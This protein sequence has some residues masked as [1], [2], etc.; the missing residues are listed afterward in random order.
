[1]H[2]LFIMIISLLMQSFTIWR[3]CFLLPVM[4]FIWLRFLLFY[5][6]LYCWRKLWN[7]FTSFAQSSKMGL[8][9]FDGQRNHK[10]HQASFEVLNIGSMLLYASMQSFLGFTVHKVY[11]S[12]GWNYCYLIPFLRKQ[13]LF[14]INI[15]I[16]SFHYHLY[17]VK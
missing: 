12:D 7:T 15:A 13:F 3:F 11:F 10:L 8:Q 9:S 17:I 6:I 16:D 4:R 1:M 5:I 2:S 14:I